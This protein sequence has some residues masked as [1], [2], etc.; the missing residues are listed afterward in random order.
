[1]FKYS[2]LVITV[3][4]FYGC[5]GS[6]SPAQEAAKKTLN[7]ASRNEIEITKV[8]PVAGIAKDTSP[9]ISFHTIKVDK[10]FLQHPDS[11]YSE[12]Q[13][14]IILAINRIDKQHLWKTD[15]LVIPDTFAIDLKFY[16]PFPARLEPVADVNKLIYFAYEIQAFAAYENGRLERWGP[17]S[18]GKRTT[19][20]P[21]GLYY[22]NWKAKVTTS[23]VNPEW[24][25]NW[26]FNLDNF[27]GVSMHEYDLPGYPASHACIRLFAE[28][29]YWFYQWADQWILSPRQSIIAQGTPVVIYGQYPFG[30]RK[31]WRYLAEDRNANDQSKETLEMNTL[32]FLPDILL[33]QRVRDS[34]L[35]R[36]LLP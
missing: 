8:D 16:S 26:Y 30:K 9:A 27:R 23:T 28:D 34:L 5:N 14:K 15:S 31:P 12:D 35:S 11:F 20:T 6:H 4:L 22:T 17:V 32:L 36:Q 10:E 1:M 18:M 3:F 25:M 24:I 21:V 29:A 13:L 7:A 2:I 33:A 19:P